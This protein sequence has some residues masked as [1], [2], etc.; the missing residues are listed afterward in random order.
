MKSDPTTT[1]CY[2]PYS[3][4]SILFHSL[5]HPSLINANLGCVGENV[6][7]DSHGEFRRVDVGI[8]N[9]ELL[10]DVIL[11]GAGQLLLT[12]TLRGEGTG[13]DKKK[14]VHV[15]H[16]QVNKKEKRR[17]RECASCERRRKKV[18]C[19]LLGEDEKKQK[20]VCVW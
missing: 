14:H 20:Y 12:H 5:Y 3:S 16:V 7:N 2:S 9:H 11:N 4:S 10:Q 13:G 19:I 6:S 17:R 1:S 18:K 15:L 8:A